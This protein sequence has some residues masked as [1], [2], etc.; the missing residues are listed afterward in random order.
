MG[1]A[2][3]RIKVGTVGK[4]FE[5]TLTEDDGITPI[6]ITGAT[7]KL[8]VERNETKACTVIDGPTG[9]ADYEAIAG[10]YPNAGVYTGSIEISD[11][12]GG[13]VSWMNDF[14]FSVEATPEPG[15]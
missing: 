4:T 8:F 2:Q 13:V 5:F 15:T 6:D 3:L 10:D 9:R 1:I 7:V 11:L 12:P 14:E